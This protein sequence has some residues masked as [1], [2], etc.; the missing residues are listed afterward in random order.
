MWQGFGS[1]GA[2]GMASVRSCEKL[3]ACPIEPMPAGSKRDLPL[4]KAE[5]SSNGGSTSV[6]PYLRRW[7][8]LLWDSS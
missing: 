5:P 7:K 4:V 1:G 3:P 6:I 8:N 2:I